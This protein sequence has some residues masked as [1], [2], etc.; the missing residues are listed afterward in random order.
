MTKVGEVDLHQDSL[1]VH[2]LLHEL[3][4]LEIVFG[5]QVGDLEEDHL[6]VGNEFLETSLIRFCQ[7]DFQQTGFLDQIP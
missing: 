6:E 1:S 2:P 5:F 7:V 4:G 3:N